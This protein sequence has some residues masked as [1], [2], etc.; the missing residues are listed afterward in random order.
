M[1][2]I[3]A[4]AG[5]FGVVIVY[6]ILILLIPEFLYSIQKWTYRSYLELRQMNEHLNH[7]PIKNKR[8]AAIGNLLTQPKAKP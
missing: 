7:L 2:S 3:A 4:I 1:E 8:I 5:L 6:A